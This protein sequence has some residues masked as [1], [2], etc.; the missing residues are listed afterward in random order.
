MNPDSSD[1][2]MAEIA[3]R[4]ADLWR[5]LTHN[6]SL[7]RVRAETRLLTDRV[8]DALDR[9]QAQLDGCGS[10]LITN[11]LFVEEC[12]HEGASTLILRVRHRDLQMH[13]AVKT[14][15]PDHADTASARAALLRE[16][17]MMMT[18][19]H[20][21]IAA[22]HMLLR[23]HDG[24][25]ALVLEWAA[26]TLAERMANGAFSLDDILTATRAILAGLVDIHAAGI[27]HAD[28]SPENILLPGEGLAALRIADF[29]IAV[30][31]GGQHASLDIEFAGRVAFA[32]P[33]QIEGKPLDAC[34]DIHACGRILQLLLDRCREACTEPMRLRAIAGKLTMPQRRD[35]PQ[36]AAAAL[37]LFDTFG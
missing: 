37:R 28:L 18:L 3:A 11:S 6:G 33:E 8:R 35:R 22:A 4:Y 19:R 36:S 24:R 5:A 25:P 34:A 10:E 2:G 29:G 13:Y 9:R 12:V 26:G 23:L 21:N 20:R 1:D 15:R 14:L 27:V 7:P 30:P 32:A 16:A 17:G 31:A